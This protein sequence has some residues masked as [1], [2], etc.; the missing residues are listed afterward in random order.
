MYVE[1]RLTPALM[2]GEVAVRVKLLAPV[3]VNSGSSFFEFVS[4]DEADTYAISVSYHT[5]YQ[6]KYDVGSGPKI[7]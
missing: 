1:P 4:K 6:Y 2:A 5:P 7:L 3:L